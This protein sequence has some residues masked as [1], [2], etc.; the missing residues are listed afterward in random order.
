MVEKNSNPSEDARRLLVQRVVSSSYLSKSARLSEMFLYLCGRVLEESVDDIHEQEVG[1]EVFGRPVHYDTMADNIVRVHASMLRKRIERYFSAEGSQ[2]PIVI[3]IPKGNYAPVFRPRPN[4]SA[5]VPQPS[6]LQSSAPQS[7]GQ[8]LP[9]FSVFSGAPP[10]HGLNWKMWLPIALAACF[11]CSTLYLL[12]RRAHSGSNLMAGETVRQ[13]WS[14][15]F[16]AHVPTDVVLDDAGLGLYQ[17]FTG[18]EIGLPA[19]FERSY[20]PTISS[21]DS[22]QIN[23]DLTGALLLRRQSSFENVSLVPKLVH[24]AGEF[25]SSANVRF[26]RDLSFHEVKDGNVILLGNSHS[27]PWIQPFERH[28]TLRWDYDTSAGAYYPVDLNAANPAKYHTAADSTRPHES[29]A[30]VAFLPNLDGNGNVLIISGTGGTAVNAALDFLSNQQSLAR[31]HSELPQ[32]RGSGLAYFEVLLRV[33]S[34]NSLRRLTSIVLC[35][36]PQA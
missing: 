18:G 11:A 10:G 32:H 3:D 33:E 24:I 28:L 35:R 6:P 12:V 29:Y 15:I 22:G 23:R 14:Q 13:F 36:Q 17:E 4:A 8:V 9:V 5:L 31:L 26:A 21:G 34:R 2:E 7:A 27:N 1:R 30:S 20:R 19:Y 16:L 25:Q